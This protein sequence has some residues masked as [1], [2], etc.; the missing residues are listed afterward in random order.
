MKKRRTAKNKHWR[1]EVLVKPAPLPIWR[2]SALNGSNR[3]AELSNAVVPT[4]EP[5]VWLSKCPQR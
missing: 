5:V 1:A 3:L 2:I 4:G